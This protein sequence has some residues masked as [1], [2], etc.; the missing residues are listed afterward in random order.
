M[1]IILPC[2]AAVKSG[3]GEAFRF[4]P[5]SIKSSKNGVPFRHEVRAIPASRSW[6]VGL[7]VAASILG[8]VPAL[9]HTTGN[10][11]VLLLP[12]GYYLAGG[13]LA[14]AFSVVVAFFLPAR[15][16][17]SLLRQR[18]DL[19]AVPEPPRVLLGSVA[20]L[21]LLGLIAAGFLGNPDPPA[22]PL[23]IVFWS[24]FWVGFPFVQAVC[25]DVWSYLNPFQAPYQL[26]RRL[27]GGR[28]FAYPPW[29]GH[30]PAVLAFIAF[31]WFELVDLAPDDPDRLA[32]AVLAYWG[33]TLLGMLL[34]G[35][36]TWLARA[37]AFTLF[38]R[39]MAALAIF[40]REVGGDGRPRLV[41]GWPGTRLLDQPPLG[42]D[43]ICFVLLTLA[44]VSFDGL[45]KTFWWLAL[46]G[47]NP[48]EFPGRSAVMELNSLGLAG[49]W[50]AL[51]AAYLLACGWNR[52]LAGRL[53]L[54]II[55]IALAYHFAHYLTVMMVD[56]Q[57][58]ARVAS[59]PF[60]LGWNLFGSASLYVTTSFLTTYS[61][62]VMIWNAQAGAIVIGHVIAIVLAQVMHAEQFVGNRLAHLPLAALMVLYTLFGLWLMATP[63]AG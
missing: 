40:R 57:Y 27:T 45:S 34:F 49:T 14:V 9:A 54:S 53:A 36:E 37:E 21:L 18:V 2:A 6:I 48:L 12:T 25:G 29:L 20:S 38:F 46:G 19:G 26:L 63:V 11:F 4:L 13:T 39:L 52:A 58:A 47:I 10:A 30:W 50:L 44:T 55:P 61:S 43:G 60:G 22:N 51:L 23:P 42:F 28:T 16:W 17:T 15:I 24:L 31:A 41:L 1:Q 33:V 59:D 5:C 7:V 8:A 32:S 62:V 56:L 35:G 3:I